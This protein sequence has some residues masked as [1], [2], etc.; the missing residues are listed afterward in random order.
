MTQ[1]VDDDY[2]KMRSEALKLLSENKAREAFSSF[3][4]ALSFPGLLQGQQRWSEAIEIFG[5]ISEQIAGKEFADLAKNAARRGSD[6]EVL[7]NFGYQLIEF[8]LPEIAATVLS[9]ANELAP[10][11]AAVLAEYVTALEMSGYHDVA[12]DAI[13]AQPKAMDATFMLQYLLAYNS[14]M[15][16]TVEEARQLLPRLKKE[17]KDEHVY[18]TS[19]IEGMVARADAVKAYTSLSVNDLRGWH[20]VINGSLLLHL[21]EYGFD[22]G[23]NGRYAFIQDSYQTCKQG[24][25]RL[26]AVLKELGVA[27]PRVFALPDRES[28][29]LAKATS[30]L[31][32]VPM[33]QWS[34]TTKEPGVIAVYD[35]ENVDT[36]VQ[37]SMLD[38]HP[39][40]ILFVHAFCW[41]M[42]PNFS[43]DI[44]TFLYQHNI[45]P[46]G[47]GLR[48]NPDSGKVEE[49]SPDESTIDSLATN[50]IDTEAMPD[51]EWNQL[52]DLLKLARGC[53][54]LRNEHGANALQNSGRRRRNRRESPVGSNRFL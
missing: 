13:R 8:N 54:K 46:W 29:I 20:F 21:S 15:C 48:A 39:G 26:E 50:I 42:P 24:I 17:T 14:I 3:R 10:G 7:Y 32:K 30:K 22:E 51:N 35:L 16:G 40:Q 18:M 6:P 34:E 2:D 41:T 53:A 25:V 28:Q 12:C 19:A 49:T 37:Q 27:V 5:R 9:R 43:P 44:T 23:M 11:E 31:L 47:A 1:A 52:E 45:A 33:V 38:H 36:E 4:W